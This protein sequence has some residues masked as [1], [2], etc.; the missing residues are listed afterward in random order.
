MP[1]ALVITVPALSEWDAFSH[2][3]DTFFQV[4]AGTALL[5]Y[6]VSRNIQHWNRDFQ[7][8]DY[9]NSTFNNRQE[10]F[11]Q[12]AFNSKVFHSR[13]WSRPLLCISA[14]G[15]EQETFQTLITLQDMFYFRPAQGARVWSVPYFPLRLEREITFGE[16]HIRILRK[17]RQPHVHCQVFNIL[18]GHMFRNFVNSVPSS[19][20]AGHRNQIL[21]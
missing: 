16:H 10:Y 20:P 12:L 7:V 6:S 4:K 3:Q 9:R 8:L 21:V 17:L 13:K 18:L 5:W 1:A 15:S 14:S 2:F 11:L 19:V